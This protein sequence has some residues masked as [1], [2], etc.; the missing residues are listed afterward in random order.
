V[1]HAAPDRRQERVG[2]PVSRRRVV[3]AGG[4]SRVF[5]RMFAAAAFIRSA[6]WRITTL[7]WE[8]LGDTLMRPIRSRIAA[9]VIERDLPAGRT[10][11]QS[12]WRSGG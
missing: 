1:E 7:Y 9:A 10:W 5:S 4:S 6:S 2:P 8:T 3:L 12:G 11:K